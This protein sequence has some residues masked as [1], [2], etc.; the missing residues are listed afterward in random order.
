LPPSDADCPTPN[1]VKF[2]GKNITPQNGGLRP[3]G[4]A[5]IGGTSAT[6]ALR[7]RGG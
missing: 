7:W 3:S 6:L 1:R 5:A 2:G 4:A